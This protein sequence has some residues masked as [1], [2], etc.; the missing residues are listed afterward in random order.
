MTEKDEDK[1][2]PWSEPKKEREVQ[3]KTLPSKA[4]DED[5]D[6]EFFKSLAKD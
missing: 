3:E 4:E 5:E 1:D 6:I 2:L